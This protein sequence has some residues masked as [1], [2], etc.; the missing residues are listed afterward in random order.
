[1]EAVGQ[2]V[3]DTMDGWELMWTEFQKISG[4]V[5]DDLDP[6]NQYFP[7][8]FTSLVFI[9]GSYAW[10]GGGYT[11]YNGGDTPKRDSG[12]FKQIVKPLALGNDWGYYH[13]WGHNINNS[14]MEHVEVT[15]NL[16]AV[17]MRKK[18]SNS[19]DDR[20]DWNL[21][22][23]RFQGE[24]VNHGYFTYLGVL[25]QLQFYYGEDSYGK[26]SSV[27]RT[28]PDGIMD[29]LD[30]NM[31]RL[32]IGFSVATE[33]D[34]TAFFEDWGYVQAT[35]K[36]KEKVAHLPKP[37]VKLEYMHS[38]GRDY[39]GAGFSKDAKLTV[40]AVKT[41]TENKQ[42]TITYGVDK[43][44]RDAAMGYEIIRDGEVIG[45]TTNTSFVDKNVDLDKV[46]HY[47]V[48]AYDKKLSSLK[49]EK[50]NSKK[51]ILSV[52]DYVTLKLRQAYD[53]MDYVKAASY[54]GNDITKDVKIKSNNIDIT[55]RET[56]KLFTK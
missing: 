34:L 1:M 54:L 27:A 23:K 24:E 33:T 2:T 9:N 25:L 7:A 40:H 3:S 36:M 47:E 51:P 38:L 16:Y 5:E 41:D 45:Y 15:N 31:Q 26:A 48:V 11:G 35:E 50:A 29:G 32:V 28:N 14:R 4:N 8:K 55:K 52:E 20:A 22:F 53:P 56:I 10:S 6:R 18:I 46:Y 30:N 17:I 13:E 43:A 19:N 39:K 21:L 49:P 12:F 42:I 44:N 37:E